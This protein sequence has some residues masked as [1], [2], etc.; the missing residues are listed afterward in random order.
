MT[1][2]LFEAVR[3]GGAGDVE[4]DLFFAVLLHVGTLGAIVAYYHRRVIDGL[5]ALLGGSAVGVTRRD[6][7][8]AVLLAGVATA[9]AVL[10]ALTLKPQIERAFNGLEAPGFGF[11]ITAVLLVA[12]TRLGGRSGARGLSEMTWTDAL[13]IGL[14]QAM[15]ITPGISRSGSTIVAGLALGFSGS[16]AVGFSLLMAVPAILGAA[17]LEILDLEPGTIAPDQWGM[18]ASATAVSGIVGLG[19][20]AWLVRI[21]RSGR[22]WYFSVYLIPLGVAVLVAAK[23][24]VGTSDPGRP[25]APPEA[26]ADRG[27]GGGTT[28]GHGRRS[29]TLD[30]AAGLGMAGSGRHRGP[31]RDDLDRHDPAG[32]RSPGAPPG[33]PSRFRGQA[34]VRPG[35]L[36][37][38][39]LA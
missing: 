4:A 8:R 22:L 15:A 33:P 28:D 6:V 16:W 27:N 11:L 19:A 7:I 37:G 9:P 20:I 1:A 26:G 3:G 32:P 38:R 31:G 10:A 13:L 24:G 35:P 18:M 39:P 14:A 30:G 2:T 12:V 29:D 23:S 25:S 17:V 21:V 34:G 5:R 36:L